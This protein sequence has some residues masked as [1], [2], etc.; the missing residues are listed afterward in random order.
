MSQLYVNLQKVAGWIKNGNASFIAD[1]VTECDNTI[2]AML[3]EGKQAEVKETLLLAGIRM[4]R[5]MGIYM[6]MSCAA[7]LNT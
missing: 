5:E 4:P 2:K 7:R 1:C 3:E 6:G